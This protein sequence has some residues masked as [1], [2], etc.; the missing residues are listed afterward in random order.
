MPILLVAHT[1]SLG[2]TDSHAVTAAH[3]RRFVMCARSPQSYS[4]HL[5]V[6]MYVTSKLTTW[7]GS[8]AWTRV[9]ADAGYLT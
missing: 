3:F 1:Y 6:Q 4:Q 2:L 9:S 5:L 8:L 7:F